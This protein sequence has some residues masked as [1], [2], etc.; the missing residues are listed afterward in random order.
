MREVAV[1][2]EQQARQA[3]HGAV[4]RE[5]RQEAAAPDGVGRAS[6][7]RL[8]HPPELQSHQVHRHEASEPSGNQPVVDDVPLHKRE[9][10]GDGDAAGHASRHE[11]QVGA[12]LLVRQCSG[13][14]E[15]GRGH[16]NGRVCG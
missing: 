10:Q 14:V 11:R 4:R 8:V 15:G 9:R 3:P 1:G 6:G 12:H 16:G 2:K 7:C 5:H 13:V